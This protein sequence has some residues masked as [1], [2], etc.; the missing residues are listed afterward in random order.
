MAGNSSAWKTMLSLPMKCTSRVPS[1]LPPGAPGLGV[2]LRLRPTRA[3]TRCSRW[4]PR[5]RRS[6][7]L[8]SWSGSGT[9][10]PQARSRVMARSPQAVARTSRGSSAARSPS[11]PGWPVEAGLERRLPCRPGAGTSA[12]SRAAPAALPS[13]ALRGS[14]SSVGLEAGA[15]ASRTGRRGRLSLPQWGQVPST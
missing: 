3:W 4:A 11:T 6:S 5:T 14:I 12:W 7:T 2:A 15:A 8:P 1:I 13:S 9:G 10:T